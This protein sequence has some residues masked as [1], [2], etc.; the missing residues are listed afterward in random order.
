MA[1]SPN[2]T[3]AHIEKIG[4]LVQ[5]KSFL[6]R[7]FLTWLWHVADTKNQV[8]LNCGEG[9]RKEWVELW[10]DD[11]ILLQPDHSSG[12]ESLMRGGDPSRSVEA[13]VA[14]GSGKS[15]KEL[16]LGLRVPSTGEFTANLSFDQLTPK[17]LQLP[18]SSPG[19]AEGEEEGG[20]HLCLRIRQTNMFLHILDE[21]FLMFLK[22]R[23]D[24]SWES[25]GLKLISEWIKAKSGKR[26]GA[27]LH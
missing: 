18:H 7:E 10:I 17:S 20:G 1:T 8:Q 15:V 14:L 5:S 27:S 21:L 4:N 23:T 9:S 25:T 11:R 22:E 6:G 24:K 16:K 13:A 2:D 3:A 26:H 19:D 12:H